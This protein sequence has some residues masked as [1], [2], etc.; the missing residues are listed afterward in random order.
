MWISKDPF[1]PQLF[2]DSATAM[3]LNCKDLEPEP[4]V[5]ELVIEYKY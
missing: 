1:Q 2:Y 5:P 3:L 4:T